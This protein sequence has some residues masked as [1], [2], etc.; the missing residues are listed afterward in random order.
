[1]TPAMKIVGDIAEAQYVWNDDTDNAMFNLVAYGDIRVVLACPHVDRWHRL[2]Y[3]AQGTATELY[4]EYVKV[5]QEKRT[6]RR[7]RAWSTMFTFGE[8]STLFQRVHPTVPPTNAA[9]YNCRECD[10]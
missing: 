9:P 2:T 8:W 10:C 3:F 6:R 7:T 4:E 1:M 5:I